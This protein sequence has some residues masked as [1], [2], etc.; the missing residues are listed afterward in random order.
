MI[1]L[2]FTAKRAPGSL[3]IRFFTW[4]RWSH[5]A[6]ICDNG[7][8]IE[9]VGFHGVRRVPMATALEKVHRYAIVEFCDGDSAN[10]ELK[11]STQIGKKYDY[12]GAIGM[13]LMRNW[14]STGRWVCSELITWGLEHIGEP[15]FRS[16]QMYKI[17]QQNLWEIHPTGAS[18]VVRVN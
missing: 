13:G 12:V 1:K 7:D 8:V 4:S 5:V 16:D 17:S 15:L 9:A 18:E 3:I 11:L 2:L 10:M 6:F 14:Q